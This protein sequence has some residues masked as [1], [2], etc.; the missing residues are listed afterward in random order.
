MSDAAAHVGQAGDAQQTLLDIIALGSRCTLEM[1][2]EYLNEMKKQ[3]RYQ[4]DVY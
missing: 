4:R 3:K 2:G 1:A